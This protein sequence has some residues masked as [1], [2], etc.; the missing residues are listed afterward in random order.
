M[1]MFNVGINVGI[2]T[3]DSI[4]KIFNYNLSSALIISNFRKQSDKGAR[5]FDVKHVLFM[6]YL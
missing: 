6:A 4:A 3:K 1:L 5:D 2:L